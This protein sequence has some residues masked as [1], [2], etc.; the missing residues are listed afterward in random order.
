MVESFATALGEHRECATA[1]ERCMLLFGRPT[2]AFLAC[3]G[4]PVAP[5][6]LTSLEA[7]GIAV[8]EG[9][10]LS[11]NSSVVAWNTPRAR[12]IGSVGRPL[13]HVQTRLADDGELLVW[14]TSL[15]AGYTVDD[16]SACALDEDGWLHTG[17]YARI[18]DDGYL[19]ILGRKKNVIITSAGRNVSPEW[20]ESRYK[21]LDCVAD[22][23]VVGDGLDS[24]H[25]LFVIDR[26]HSLS[27]A[28]EQIAAFGRTQLSEIE[29]VHLAH[30]VHGHDELQR[31]YFTVTGRPIRDRIREL[32]ITA[33]QPLTE[34]TNDMI[35]ITPYGTAT[36]T[37]KVVAAAAGTTLSHLLAEDLLDMLRDA[38]FLLL[39]G[40]EPD[41]DGFAQLV[42]RVSGKVTLDPARAFS[43]DVAQK[44]DAGLGAVGLHCENG[45]APLLP[46]LTWFFCE[47]AAKRGSQTT[48]CDGFRV[49]DALSPAARDAFGAQ[50]IVYSRRVDEAKWK[51]FVAHTLGKDEP[52]AEIGLDDLEHVMA[53]SD[54][55]TYEELED[56]AIRYSFAVGAAHPTLWSERLAFANSILGPSFNYE[57][58]RITFRDGSEIPANLLEE[59]E[60]VTGELSEDLDWVDGD[61]ALIDNTRVMH[62]RRAILDAD[63][64]IYNALSYVAPVATAVA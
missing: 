60:R 35:K 52:A 53:L 63:R 21:T 39:R 26:S 59:V 28:A 2:P 30:V 5:E 62:G 41:I 45:N 47:K 56:G 32:V 13:D 15:F 61:I 18:D 42:R 37:G 40:F 10:G 44:V 55:T 64:T 4:A 46:H 48:V 38:G 1:A 50:E 24:L 23:V 11:E 57:K 8:Y 6:L 9:Y 36:G 51:T 17:D 20:T 58:P 43:G 33:A 34:S 27:R 14:S 16:P 31:N 7:A 19:H 54:G 49:W 3:G 25:G 29:R 22:A 12:R